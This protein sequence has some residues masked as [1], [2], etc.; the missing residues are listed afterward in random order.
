MIASGLDLPCFFDADCHESGQHTLPDT[1]AHHA[2]HVLRLS[3]GNKLLVSN[4]CGIIWLSE[5]IDANKRQVVYSTINKIVDEPKSPFKNSIA[6]GIIGTAARQ[7]WM[8]EKLVEIGVANI[9][10]VQT[11]YAKR[12]HVNE[13]RL[14]KTAIAALKQS[15][16]AFL[17][18]IEIL[19]FNEL[20]HKPIADKYVAIC[21]D[22]P[23]TALQN[24]AHQGESLV[25]TG[26]EGDFTNEEIEAC[27]HNGFVPCS[28]GSE[29]L[30]S[31]TAAVYSLI[32]QN[33]KNQ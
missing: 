11:T 28:L 31:E 3:V 20:M 7:E 29:R 4:G 15:R 10:L 18:A 5:I 9:F 13:D 19:E 14:K 23:K 2:L 8:I 16:K 27:L 30:R 26:P 6:C 1:E 12:K 33:L 22:M 25:F 21:N 17:P 32:C 24:F